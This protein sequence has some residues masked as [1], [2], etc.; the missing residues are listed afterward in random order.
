LI[1]ACFSADFDSKLSDLLAIVKGNT[2]WKGNGDDIAR[3]SSRVGHKAVE[4][5]PERRIRIDHRN[6]SDQT[7]KSTWSRTW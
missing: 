4:S 6:D 5:M 1:R 7:Y 2:Y 3:A